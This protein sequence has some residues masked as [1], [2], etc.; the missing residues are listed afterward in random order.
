MSDKTEKVLGEMFA[1]A[2]ALPWDVEDMETAHL[3]ARFAYENVGDESY[4]L[5]PNDTCEFLA[6][7]ISEQLDTADEYTKDFYRELANFDRK[8]MKLIA[9]RGKL[10]EQ[11]DIPIGGKQWARLNT[12]DM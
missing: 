10:A 9:L 11:I 1:V 7:D 3:E 6:G 2:Q 5:R 4:F 8:L 12:F